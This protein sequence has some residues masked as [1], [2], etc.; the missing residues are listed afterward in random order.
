MF[1]K[2]VTASFSADRSTSGRVF[3]ILR[4]M[5][6]TQELKPGER[7]VEAK[8]AKALQVSITPV[9]QAFASLSAQGLLT[10]FPYRGT[11]VTI[12]TKEYAM[13]LFNVRAALEPK[14]V[15]MA[16]P[17]LKAEDADYLAQQCELSDEC[18][19]NEDFLSSIEYD[20]LFHE[21][22]FQKCGNALMYEIWNLIKNRVTF[23]Q[24]ISRHNCQAETPLLVTRHGEIIDAVRRMDEDALA[25]AMTRHLFTTLARA[26]PPSADSVV[27]K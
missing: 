19:R 26:M 27:Y 25:D 15:R 18:N 22:F 14:V 1:S 10:V 3:E 17:H 11:Y 20:I 8:I 21:F 2:E 24:C 9:R 23:F 13:D 6:L 7:L 4:R 16:F 5:I 12:L